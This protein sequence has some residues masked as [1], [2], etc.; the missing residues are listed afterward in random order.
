[1]ARHELSYDESMN[2][3]GEALQADPSNPR[4]RLRLA[5]LSYRH[6]HFERGDDCLAEALVADVAAGGPVLESVMLFSLL[7]VTG[8]DSREILDDIELGAEH[9]SG[10]ALIYRGALRAQRGDATG[11]REDEAAFR[12]RALRDPRLGD[13]VGLDELVGATIDER[14]RRA[15]RPGLARRK[16]ST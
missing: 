3:V 11:A 1:M 16:V 4:S 8:Y 7:L 10:P 6:G 13:L 2:L 12:E 15:G 9:G 5:A 14:I